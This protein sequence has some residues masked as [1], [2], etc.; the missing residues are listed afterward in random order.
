M[1]P[2]VEKGRIKAS[3]IIPCYNAEDTLQVQ[4]DALC[5]QEWLEPWEVILSDNGSTDGS[6]QIAQRYFNH[7]PNFKIIDSSKIKGPAYARNRGVEASR[8]EFLFFCDADDEVAP[9]WVAA[10]AKGVESHDFVA[11]RFESLKLNDAA[12]RRAG[13]SVQNN[14]IQEYTYPSFLP[15]AGAG[16]L[17]IKRDIHMAVGG[18]DETMP[19]L[20]DTD[21][22]WRVQLL[23]TKLVFAPD[24]VIHHRLRTSRRKMFRQSRLWGEFNV[25]LYKKYR[26]FGMPKLSKKEGVVKFWRL[27]R[28]MPYNM[29]HPERRNQWLRQFAWRFGRIIGSIKYRT[30][31]L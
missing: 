26:P 6:K 3:V 7:L 9:G 31:A 2:T 21:Y 28:R 4:L 30:F 23:G 17:G 25:Y 24:A 20:E 5:A 11:C 13:G 19:M 16:G 29:K 14:G 12:A 8:G 1:N 18:F 10:M 22:C 15:H 27:L